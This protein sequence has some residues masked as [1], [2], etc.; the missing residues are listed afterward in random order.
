MSNLIIL[1][2]FISALIGAVGG[3]NQNSIKKILVYSSITHGAWIIFSII[4]KQNLWIIYFTIYNIGLLVICLL[5]EKF[6]IKKISDIRNRKF[7]TNIKMVFIVNILSIAGLPPFLG[8][9]GKL[10]VISSMIYSIKMIFSLIVILRA[11]LISL[12]YYINICYSTYLISEKKIFTKKIQI[13]K[14]TTLL[15]LMVIS[16]IGPIMVYLA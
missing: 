2:I 4:I 15:I 6:E 11:S 9:F 14:S 7:I 10:I 16:I 5:I 1:V 13:N 3:I 8:F 12:I